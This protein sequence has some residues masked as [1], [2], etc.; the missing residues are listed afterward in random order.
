MTPSLSPRHKCVDGSRCRGQRN[1]FASACGL[2]VGHESTAGVRSRSDTAKLS[3]TWHL[4]SPAQ[5]DVP[6]T[7][8]VVRILSSSHNE[9]WVADKRKAMG[10]RSV[11]P[12]A[13]RRAREGQL[14]SRGGLLETG[15]LRQICAVSRMARRR[16]GSRC[17]CAHR[18]RQPRAQHQQRSEGLVV[19]CD[20]PFR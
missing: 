19:G 9:C 15:T 8:A 3:S 12:S 6:P 1:I 16:G 2:A 18:Q 17:R 14:G 11:R 13:I 10:R 5:T 4:Y 20:R 7:V